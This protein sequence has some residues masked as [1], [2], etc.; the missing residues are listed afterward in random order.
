[1]EIIACYTMVNDA[2]L[3]KFSAVEPENMPDEI[4]NISETHELL[5]IDKLWDG[6]HFLLTGSSSSDPIVE[7]PISEAIVGVTNL[8]EDDFI[9]CIRY[10]ELHDIVDALDS[11][12]FPKLKAVFDPSAFNKA[13]VYPNIWADNKKDELFD[14][15]EDAF[16]NL[17]LFYRQALLEKMN[18]I[19]SIY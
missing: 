3:A 9:A 16:N 7:D 13:E 11:I 1:M 18:I 12:D 15:L 10:E 14:R 8:N 19:V 6:L 4:E 17:L 2:E 5:D